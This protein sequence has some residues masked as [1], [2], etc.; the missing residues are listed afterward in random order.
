MEYI[1][2]DFVIGSAF[3]KGRLV[4]VGNTSHTTHNTKNVVIC[5]VNSNLGGRCSG[6]SSRRKNK[7]KSSVVNSG[8]VACSRGLVFLR[9]KSEGVKVDTGVWVAGVVLE[10][11]NGIE[12]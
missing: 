12:V 9:A 10:W 3:F 1:F 5:G 7:L 6:N 11:L 8:E 2:E 4:A